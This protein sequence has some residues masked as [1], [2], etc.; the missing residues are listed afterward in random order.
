M[1]IAMY[2]D[3]FYPTINGV[4]T[5][6]VNLA[7]SLHKN[8]HDVFIQAPKYPGNAVPPD[9]PKEIQII[10]V[11]S[12]NARIYPD[13]RIGT[14][15]PLS[16]NKIRAFNPDLIHVHSPFSIGIEGTLI[17]AALRMPMIYTFHTNF[18]DEDALRAIG[19][20]NKHLIPIII[21]GGWRFNAAFCNRFTSIIT[22]SQSVNRD[23][24]KHFIKRPIFTAPNML[25]ENLFHSPKKKKHLHKLIFVGRLSK[26][27]R[28]HLTIKA[29]AKLQQTDPRYKLIIIG[30]G[31][32]R[33]NLFNLSVKLGVAPQIT[34]YG[35]VPH[36]ELIANSLYRQ[37]DLFVVSSKFETQGLSTLEA[38]AQGLPVVAVQSDTNKEVV[39]QGGIVVKN[40]KLESRTV[41]ALAKAIEQINNSNHDYT[42][43]AF[44]EAKKYSSDN[45]Y[46]QYEKIYQETI[47]LHQQ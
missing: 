39:K 35:K 43:L 18:M 29:L 11:K 34:W 25:D 17:A 31:P 19:L 37:G 2:T 15:L 45:L 8:G 33:E 6:I 13:F 44:Q 36:H 30:D 5:A 46:P 41:S 16:L 9:F 24:K 26:E 42:Q 47:K 40:S 28:I 22:P 10:S 12:V 27:K 20:N 23:L 3:S 21:K 1:R 14:G 7:K 38:M 32:D 4:N